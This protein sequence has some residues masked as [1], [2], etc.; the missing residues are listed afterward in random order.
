MHSQYSIEQKLGRL[1]YLCNHA[2]GDLSLEAEFIGLIDELSLEGLMLRPE[3]YRK[4]FELFKLIHFTN[5]KMEPLSK[6]QLKM[7]STLHYLPTDPLEVGPQASDI[8]MQSIPGIKYI[9]HVT[10][11]IMPIGNPIKIPGVQ[12][13]TLT[14]D[15]R[16]MNRIIRPMPKVTVGLERSE[17]D[18]PIYNYGMI[19]H[20]WRYPATFRA[21][22]HSWYNITSVVIDNL[23]KVA[24]QS[25]RQQ[26]LTVGIP[27][28]IPT[29][30]IL[31]TF[32][33]SKTSLT[34]KA[35]RTFEDYTF[36][37]LFIWAGK[38]RENSLLAKIPE[39]LY[40][41]IDLLI[42][43]MDKWVVINL[44]WL[45]NLRKSDAKSPGSFDP[46]MF[47]LKM[48]QLFNILHDRSEP[49]ALS[50][51][52]PEVTEPNEA[53]TELENEVD[54]IIT[55]LDAGFDTDVD[56][57]ERAADNDD[58]ER[59]EKELLELD[60]LKELS[61]D[62]ES[63]DD[64]G[65]V[66]EGAG[67]LIEAVGEVGSVKS[68]TVGIVDRAEDLAKRGVLSSREYARLHRLNEKYAT[69]PD[70]YGSGKSILEAGAMKLEDT[71]IDSEIISEDPEVLDPSMAKASIEVFDTTYINEIMPKDYINVVR[72]LRRGPVAVMDHRVERH[73]DAS[74]DLETHVIKLTPAIG[75]SSTIRIP[76]PRVTPEGTFIYNGT[77]YRQKKQRRDVPIRKISPSK[78]VISNIAGN[79]SFIQ[80]SER[81]KFDRAK[82][83]T[84]EVRA[85]CT[86]SNSTLVTEASLTKVVD[87]TAKT[88]WTYS[89]M[90]TEISSFKV[91]GYTLNFDYKYRERNNGYTAEEMKLEK[92]GWVLCGRGK[93]GPLGMDPSGHI[94]EWI[95]D[96]W[97][98]VG[99]VESLLEINVQKQA[100]PMAELKVYTAQIPIGVALGYLIGLS[101]LLSVAKIKHRRTLPGERQNLTDEEFA[102]RF[103]N[104]VL[105][106][107]MRDPMTTLIM[108]GWMM[109]AD[110]LREYDVK[111]FDA[112]DV[113]SVALERSGITSWF[114]K[115][116]DTMNMYFIDPITEDLLKMLNE[117]T[118]FVGLLVRATEMI[119]DEHVPAKRMDENGIA[120]LYERVAGYDRFPG[121][122]YDVLYKAMRS[123]INRAGTGRASIVVNPNDAINKIIRDGC[124]APVNNINPLHGQRER[125]VITFGGD[126]GRSRRAMVADTRLYPE[127]D[128]GFISEASVD[129]GDVG[130]ITY[131]AP[132]ANLRS[133]RGTVRLYDKK[134]DG[135]GMLL[136]TPAQMA[137]FADGD[138]LKRVGFISTQSGHR[139]S[140]SHGEVQPSRTGG[141]RTLINRVGKEFGHSAKEDGVVKSVSDKAIVIELKSKK[142][143]RLPLGLIHTNAEGAHY[144]TV[145]KTP[146]VAG[147]KFKKFDVITYNENFFKPSPLNPRRVDYMQGTV[148]FIALREAT[149]TYEDSSSIAAEF[150]ERLVANTSK[151]VPVTV[152]YDQI[153]SGLVAVGDKV[154][155]ESPLCVI[156]NYVGDDESLYDE[157]TRSIL[158]EQAK[159]APPAKV[160]GEVAAIEVRYNGD[161]ELMSESLRKVAAKSDRER[162]ALA[163]ALGIPYHPGKITRFQRVEGHHVEEGQA[164][165]IIHI[166]NVQGM[167]VGDK[168]VV[169]NQLKSTVGEVL[170]GE[171]TTEQGEKLDMI[172]GAI[173]VLNR[174]VVSVFKFGPINTYMRYTGEEAYRMY[175][176][177]T[178]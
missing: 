3:V 178:A 23:V 60:K 91:K 124:T 157:R 128:K 64:D 17:R 154:D 137:P 70:P 76:M 38:W 166:T 123:Y 10:D 4:R 83:L 29:L 18:V 155:L 151:V 172:F 93:K 95:N 108:S 34:L 82:S 145:L 55:T 80:R 132:N 49:I 175:F 15:Y 176:E 129:S 147:D 161:I 104:E 26:V 68:D 19:Q 169:G 30:D 75:D 107:N 97:E 6:I 160:V 1:N 113:Y 9:Q 53:A 62:Y 149:Y 103:K 102:I 5:P 89:T 56:D 171:N 16:M 13:T 159:M 57:V 134:R 92:K 139:I 106:V 59:L 142:E 117:P 100:I 86:D 127:E 111:L 143:V 65:N 152:N 39:D 78:V 85:R 120:D 79:K 66:N 90:G 41:K 63:I 146:L 153:I 110:V 105:I 177:E 35:L 99:T 54:D 50:S 46:L 118:D 2:E 88:P 12:V 130:I 42:R 122:M 52:E 98:S 174:I 51:D 14:T 114:L 84:R 116:L 73:S 8:L 45:N 20:L 168:L 22:Y 24:R 164:V 115:E 61:Q 125:E 21:D 144:P 121:A 48:L 43:R 140:I 165:I 25:S 126:G 11:L 74:N 96:S 173:S 7:F 131:L 37:D 28:V 33:N 141:E 138:D 148:G 119:L 69:L 47:E 32:R 81:T 31:R 109:Y 162:K 135:V 158:R 44:G 170:F 94:Y 40:P 156:E 163:D 71:Y 72:S 101:T 77:E 58:M 36:A 67:K 27:D 112:K 167:T 133:V 136:S 87:Y 150:A